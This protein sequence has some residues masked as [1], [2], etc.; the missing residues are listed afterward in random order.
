MMRRVVAASLLFAAALLAASFRLYLKDGSY[1]LVREYQ[2]SGD[3]VRFYSIERSE[4]EE[5]PTSLADLNRTEQE[6][7]ARQENE[8]KEVQ[9]SAA[10]EKLEREQQAEREKVPQDQGVYLV[11]GPDL[12]TIKQAESKVVTNKGR[13]VLKVVAP[14]PVVSGKASVELDGEHSANLVNSNEPEFYIRLSSDER[15]GILRLWPKKGARIVQKWTI[16]PITK[17]ISEE[18][19]EIECFRKQADDGVYKI[20]PAKPLD[21]GEYA[22]VEWT[23]GKRN[24]QIWDFSY[25]PAAAR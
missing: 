7:T 17:E 20:W 11:A 3:R 24:I 1:Q 21:P 16:V 19:Q 6:K 12:K 2:V 14:L 5:I 10:E 9:E 22:V 15:Y 13:S 23:Q 25:R 18:Q 8:Q 4:W